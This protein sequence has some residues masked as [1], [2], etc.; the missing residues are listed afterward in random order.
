[1]A[2]NFK[3]SDIKPVDA[4]DDP[5]GRTWVGYEPTRTAEALFEQNRGIWHLGV[6]A[7]E[8]S[9][10]TFS[11]AGKVV[12]VAEID[13]IETLPWSKPEGRRDKKA[14]AG[15]VLERG[16]PVHDHFVG[17]MVDGYRNPVTYIDDPGG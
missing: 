6:R 8:Q 15:R 11:Y 9:Y 4:Q 1:M 7:A 10:A 16:H 17:L 13:E 3:L 12:L 14:V 2:I 5:M